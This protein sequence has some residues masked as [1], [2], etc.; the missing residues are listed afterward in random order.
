MTS[1]IGH[2]ISDRLRI[3]FLHGPV[4]TKNVS[5]SRY[6][7]HRVIAREFAR[8][9]E[10]RAPPDLVLCSFPTIELSAAAV[11]FGRQHRIPVFLDIRDLWPDEIL[12]R[13]PLALRGVGRL[14]L[15]PMFQEAGQAL[16]G[17]T[18]IVG[19]SETYLDWALSRARRGP[20]SSDRVFPL[21]YTGQLSRSEPGPEIGA[22]LRALGVN[23]AR[24]V[25]WFSGT[26]VGSIDLG[27]VIEAA[28]ALTGNPA[29]QFVFSGA[30]ERDKEWRRQAAGL[31]N[32]VFTGWVGSEELLWLSRV[33]WAGLAAYRVGASMSLP[34][35]LFEYMSMGLP[36]LLGLEGEAKALVV[37]EALGATYEPGNVGNLVEVISRIAQDDEWRSECALRA[38]R[39][40]EDRYSIETLYARYADFLEDQCRQ[41]SR[42]SH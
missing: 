12:A 21:G 41:F 19:I 6:R 11:A 37:G 16:K 29:I 24:K 28:R 32:V 18:G 1:S 9:V 36:V 5:V 4:Y 33:A 31:E 26:F 27:T 38:R 39:L 23:P 20:T 30:G 8:L 15:W 17:A 3:Q 10:R 42:R 14:M 7:N 25:L 2:E 22:K 34:N 35:K 13:V 40:F